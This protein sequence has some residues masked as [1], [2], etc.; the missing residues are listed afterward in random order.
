MSLT[1]NH[2]SIRTTDL[3]AT[4]AFYE[5]VLGLTVGPRPAFP[6]P[7]LWMYRGDHADPSNAVVHVIGID[8]NDPEGLKNYLGDRDLASLQGS[9]AVDHV[10][11]FATGLAGMLA[12]LAA[13]G[14]AV[15][16]RTVPNLG[17]HQLF[18]DDPNGVV[19]ELNYPA[20]EKAALG[21]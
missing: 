13:Q 14:V 16:E 1:L 4:R 3:D 15:R 20:A 2:F 7:G 17:L 18:L 9:G 21:A 19:I 8:L 6:F 11:F 5:G 12:R 10:A